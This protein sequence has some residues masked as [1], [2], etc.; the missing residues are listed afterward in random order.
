MHPTRL[1][2][3]H[4]PTILSTFLAHHE[5]HGG[6][7]DGDPDHLVPRGEEGLALLRHRV[8]ARRLHSGVELGPRLLGVLEVT[9]EGSSVPSL[10][11][12]GQASGVFRG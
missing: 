4:H 2:F 1:N 10:T 9:A 6:R 8:D 11:L 12:Q 3:P 7:G 5:D